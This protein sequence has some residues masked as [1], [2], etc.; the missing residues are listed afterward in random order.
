VLDGEITITR[1]GK[2]QT[3]RAGDSCEVPAGT[4]H[5]EQIGPEGVRY[6]AGRRQPA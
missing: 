3:F 4:V 1:G 6:L 2:A 5:A